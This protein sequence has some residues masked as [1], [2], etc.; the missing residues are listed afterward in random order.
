MKRVIVP[1]LV[2]MI[3]MAAACTREAKTETLSL[4]EHDTQQTNLT[5]GRTGSNP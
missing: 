2:V 5:L 3:A 4:Y 1:A